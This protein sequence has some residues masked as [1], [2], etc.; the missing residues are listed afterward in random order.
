MPLQWKPLQENTANRQ[1]DISLKKEEKTDKSNTSYVISCVK[2]N[3][4]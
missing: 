4:D 3:P 1:R 2:K